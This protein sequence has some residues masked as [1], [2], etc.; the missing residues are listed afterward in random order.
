[1]CSEQ[2]FNYLIQVCNSIKE[3]HKE[4]DELYFDYLV[5][6]RDRQFLLKEK[7][8]YNQIAMTF[9][10]NLREGLPEGEDRTNLINIEYFLHK[11]FLSSV[12]SDQDLTKDERDNLKLY[13]TV[14]SSSFHQKFIHTL[15]LYDIDAKLPLESKRDEILYFCR[16]RIDLINNALSGPGE[17]SLLT[18]LTIKL[19][20]MADVENSYLNILMKGDIKT[21]LLAED[22]RDTLSLL[23]NIFSI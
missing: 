5:Q 21:L 1:M 9:L 12:G 11:I 23:N 8:F 10:H 7:T 6:R 2:S 16:I 20:K 3:K 15:K 19:L 17:K 18:E 13:L 22:L 14:F 4:L